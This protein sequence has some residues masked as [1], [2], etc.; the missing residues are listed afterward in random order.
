[1]AVNVSPRQFREPDF[2]VRVAEILKPSQLDPEVLELEVTEGSVMK[3]IHDAIEKLNMLNAMGIHLSVDDFGT[4][5]S[6]LSYLI[7]L[8]IH[9]LKIDKSFISNMVEDQRTQ[10]SLDW[11]LL[12]KVWKGR[13]RGN[14]YRTG[15]VTYCKAISSVSRLLAI[16]SKSYLASILEKQEPFLLKS[17]ITEQPLICLCVSSEPGRGVLLRLARYHFSL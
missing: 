16:S 17:R 8:P 15:G 9:S 4:G 11:M 12:P 3:N 6:S 5:Y 13:N 14:C 10:A 1:M 7:K 2:P